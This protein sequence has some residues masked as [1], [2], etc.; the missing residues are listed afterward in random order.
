MIRADIS[1]DLVA[2]LSA[3][4]G[5]RLSRSPEVRRQHG[6]GESHHAAMPPDIV[7]HPRSTEEV[8]TIARLCHQAGIAMI[9]FGAG[10]SLEGNVLALEGGVCI[11]LREMDAV[12]RV[13]AEDLD[14]T[15]Q[16]GVTRLQLN[17]ALRDTG[18]F[19]PID[20]GADAT[21]GGMTATRASGTNAVRYGTMR[22][23]VLSLTVVLADGTVMRTGG[24]ARKSSAGYDMTRLFVGSE[25][26]LGIVTEVTLRLHGIPESVRVARCNFA[27]LD[28]AVTTV[29]Q[30]MQM[31]IPIARIELADAAQMRAINAFAKT[32]YPERDTL[33][34]ECHGAESAVDGQ[35]ALVEMLAA[36]NGGQDWSVAATAEERGRLWQARH[37][38]LYATTA[39]RP[40]SRG[41]ITDVCVPLSRLAECIALAQALMAEASFPA[42]IVGHVGDGNFHVIC[43][44]DPSS[45][46]ER[47]EAEALGS[48]L[49]KLAI[50]LGGTCTGEHGI[51]NG[52]LDYMVL[53]HGAEGVEAMRM[54][55]RALDP[56]GLLNPG[57]VLPNGNKEL[58][59]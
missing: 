22:D 29:T 12:L 55:K 36:D 31:G 50:S 21:I 54:V 53:E 16:A 14:C 7:V 30:I 20:P 23:A 45:K 4:C 35:M 47:V 37:D 46:A 10:T 41:F 13:S 26:T 17:R 40:G 27:K 43:P 25:G 28:D 32:D 8:S 9:A 48:A 1:E 34:F 42:T 57:K 59:E 52:K 3:A 5:G 33:F 2:A 49:S 15:V 19:F 6:G 38:A 11:D 44:I 39:Q 56:K 51:G 18:L 24:R 58:A